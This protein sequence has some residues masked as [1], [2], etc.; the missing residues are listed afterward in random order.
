MSFISTAYAMGAG[1]S[2]GGEQ[3]DMLA[4]LFPF[5]LIFAVFYFLL[6]RPQQKKAKE[7]KAMI[8]ALKKGDAVITAGGLLGRI[9]DVDGDV[10]TVD[11]GETT[12]RVGRAYLTAAPEK[13]QAAPALKK[14]KKG[15][16]DAP[17]A[18]QAE[19]VQ[20]EA[21]KEEAAPEA[22]GAVAQAETPESGDASV[23]SGADKDKPIVQ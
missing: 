21:V 22:S 13:K 17:K 14:E 23:V 2:A 10:M 9:L 19:P 20:V 12:V 7:H 5:I 15:R 1:P 4:S 11:L 8:E 16:K 3:P 6:I 18:A